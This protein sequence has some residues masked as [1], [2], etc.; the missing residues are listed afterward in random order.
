MLL[1]LLAC[2]ATPGGVQSLPSAH[3][4]PPSV[5]DWP[6]YGRDPGGS[7]YSPAAEITRENV[8]RLQVAWTYR[9]GDWSHDGNTRSPANSESTPIFVDGTLYVTSPFGRVI[10][11]DPATG[12]ERWN[13]DPKIDLQVGWGDF[14]NRGVSTWSDPSRPA[15]A[16]CRR[17]IFVAPIDARLI[18]LDAAT[19]RPCA[20]FGDSGTVSLRRGLVNGPA[21]TSEYQITSPPA[22]VGDVVVLGSSVADNYR[23]D[24]AS[25]EVRA[26]DARTGA[27]RWRWDPVSRDSAAAAADGW[28]GREAWRTGAANAW[29]V[30]SAD[31]E[32]DLVFVPTSS[33]SPDYYGGRRLGD[34]RG[35]NSVVA[36]RASTGRVVW[37]FQVV[38]HDLWDYD[39]PAQPV[40]VT[41]RRGGRDVPAVV[42]LTKMGLVFVLDRETGRPFFPIEER[43]VPRSSVPGE[44]ASPTQPFPT[45]IDA[46]VPMHSLTADSAWGV[47]EADRGACRDRARGYRNEGIYTPP[48]VDGSIVFP[49]NVGGS[50][51]SGGAVDPTRGLLIANTNRFAAL[52]RLI[53]RDSAQA[54]VGQRLQRE[55]GAQRGTPYVIE[56]DYWWTA[57]RVPCTRPP[58]GALTALDLSTGRVRWE[59]PLGVHPALA[60]RPEARQYGML[61]LGGAIVTAGGV[62]FIGATMDAMFRAFDVETGRLLWETPV[63]YSATATPMTYRAANGKQYVVVSAGGYGRVGMP[64]GDHVVAFALP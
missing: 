60:G 31:P 8:S 9:T 15:G 13:F 16:P 20:D 19:G 12:R 4:P 36:I 28:R 63:P 47:T 57:Q 25:G 7:R 46:I 22:V 52:I 61:N 54:V 18:A 42:Q 44:E 51:W 50:N 49:G 5:A 32:R 48:S 11:L 17:R 29:A 21:Y 2:R 40:L 35:A 59:V 43:A 24:A 45:G 41:L 23:V 10:A 27:L 39:V 55:Y 34:N 14:T 38:H 3:S 56:R 53:P 58:W 30:I 64:T 6:S 62:V 1:A 37:R 26:F 33:P